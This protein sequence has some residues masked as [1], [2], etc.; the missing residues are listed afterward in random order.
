MSMKAIWV[1]SGL[2]QQAVIPHDPFGS[3]NEDFS[4]PFIASQRKTNGSDPTYPETTT[5][6]FADIFKAIMSS[7]WKFYSILDFPL[8]FFGI[9]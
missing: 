9:S 8:G 7:L 5:L 2:T 4:S 6:Q 3:L 1:L